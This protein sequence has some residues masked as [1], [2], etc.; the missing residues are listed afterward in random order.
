MTSATPEEPRTGSGTTR[1]WQL[2][3][4]PCADGTLP[5]M[6]CGST[7]VSQILLD[8]SASYQH[9]RSCLPPGSRGA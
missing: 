9:P 8:A 4:L 1:R 5:L 6:I 7:Q 2:D 3:W